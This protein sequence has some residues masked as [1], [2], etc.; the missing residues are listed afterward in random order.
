MSEPSA[1]RTQPAAPCSCGADAAPA[2]QSCCG[3]TTTVTSATMDAAQGEAAACGCR[4]D[5]RQTYAYGPAAYVDGSVESRGGPVRRVS[6]RLSGRDRRGAWR[7]RWG[8]GR[9]DYRVEP[10]LYAVGSPGADAPV[11]VTANY[12]LTFDQPARGPRRADA[13]MLVLDTRG[14]NVW[15]AAGK[16]TFGTREVVRMVEAD[17]P[18]PRS[19]TTAASILPQLGAPGVAAHEVKK[20]SGFRASSGRCGRPTCR[21]SSP[22]AWRRRRDAAPSLPTCASAPSLAPVELS[23]ALAPGAGAHRRRPRHLGAGRRAG[24]RCGVPQRRPV[25]GCR[26]LCRASLPAAAW[27]RPL[28]CPGCRVARSPSRAPPSAL[29]WRPAAVPGAAIRGCRAAAGSACCPAC[30]RLRRYLAMNFTGSTPYTSPPGCSARCAAPSVPGSRRG[31]AVGRRSLA[32]VSRGDAMQGCATSK[33]AVTLQLDAERCTGCGLCVES[34]HT[35]SSRSTAARWSS[36]TA[37]P[38]WSAA[39]ARSTASPGPS[40]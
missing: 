17:R 7:V 15:C 10:G 13:W 18:R 27:S 25:L 38:A 11:L 12:K 32:K 31:R 9:D 20:G 2:K 22:P 37:A 23:A 4:S 39:P 29:R 33:D 3:S 24:R 28:C 36:P 26:P 16:G 40:P 30:R 1:S 8:M 35:P 19:S 6:T 34:V 21:P 14:I 5:Q